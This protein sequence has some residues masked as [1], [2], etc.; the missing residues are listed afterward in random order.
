M[1]NDIYVNQFLKNIKENKY[2]INFIKIPDEVPDWTQLL[3]MS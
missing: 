2:K 3:I 1:K